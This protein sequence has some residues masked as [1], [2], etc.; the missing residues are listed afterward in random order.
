M[1]WISSI[2]WKTSIFF[3]IIGFMKFFY[4]FAWLDMKWTFP[5]QFSFSSWTWTELR[6]HYI[7][8]TWM[9]LTS[10]KKGLYN[11]LYMTSTILACSLSFSVPLFT[12]LFWIFQ[13]ISG[14]SFTSIMN[15]LICQWKIGILHLNSKMHSISM[16]FPNGYAGPRKCTG[17][18]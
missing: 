16:L 9:V 14:K 12:F 15:P 2:F 13:K 4:K 17:S 11:A 18:Q 7:K 3:K 6:S 8:G 5:V 10:W 1:Q